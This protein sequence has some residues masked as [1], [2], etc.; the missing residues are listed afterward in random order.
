MLYD[1]IKK[2]LILQNIFGKEVDFF[3]PVEKI[4]GE[5]YSFSI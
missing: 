1:F 4:D 5:T 2:I 3:A